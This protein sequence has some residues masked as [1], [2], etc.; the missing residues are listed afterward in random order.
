MPDHRELLRYA[1]EALYGD[2]WQT[3]L[4]RGVGVADR[5][6]RRW[7][8]EPHIIPRGIWSDIQALL[9]NR[10]V[11]IENARQS[12]TRAMADAPE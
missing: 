12:I 2:R 7:V 10:V 11:A 9:L 8:A 4:A 3:D 1:G 5:T 6:M